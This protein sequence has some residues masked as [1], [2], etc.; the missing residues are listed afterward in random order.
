ML[1]LIISQ[2]KI[3]YPLFIITG[4][5]S[6]KIF[7]ICVYLPYTPERGKRIKIHLAKVYFWPWYLWNSN[8]LEGCK[9]QL[10]T[11]GDCKECA[12]YICN[13][14]RELV[15]IKW[16]ERRIFTLGNRGKEN[17]PGKMEH[18]RIIEIYLLLWRTMRTTT[19]FL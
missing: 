13:P 15:L 1:T 19:Y 17:V 5:S 7:S 10:C 9:N 11:Y 12:F 4:E 6:R 16:R 14:V 18:G 8:E 3:C 2:D